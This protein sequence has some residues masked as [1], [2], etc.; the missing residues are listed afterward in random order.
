MPYLLGAQGSLEAC[1]DAEL[2]EDV[3][4]VDLHGADADEKALGYSW[5]RK[6]LSKQIQDLTLP[7][8]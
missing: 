2:L 7:H 6:A 1:L 3:P 4:N 5:I 8:C